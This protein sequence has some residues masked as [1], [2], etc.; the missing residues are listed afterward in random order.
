MSAIEL[1]KIAKQK[2]DN[3]QTDRDN[4]AAFVAAMVEY[5]WSDADVSE[6]KLEVGR[7]MK[8]GTDEEKLAASQFWSNFVGSN[9][10]S[11]IN[12][13]IRDSINKQKDD[14]SCT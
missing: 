6:Y 7:I 9:P 3:L 2:S 10:A 8:H 14:K 13:R 11:G 4:Y 12:A 5:G 1:L